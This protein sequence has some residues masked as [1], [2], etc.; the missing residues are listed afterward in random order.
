MA[1]AQTQH[2]GP[3]R[4]WF[5][6]LS[7]TERALLFLTVIGFGFTLADPAIYD[8]A[9]QLDPHTRSL[10]DSI[11]HFGKSSWIL[12]PTGLVFIV[13]MALRTPDM[14]RR[15]RVALDHWMGVFGITFLAVAGSG[16][17]CQVFKTIIGRARPEFYDTLGPLTFRPLAF[18]SGFASFPSGHATTIFAFAAAVSLMVPPLRAWAFTFAVWVAASRFFIDAHYFTDV[19]AGGI[20]GVGFMLWLARSFAK[21][22]I[23]FDMRDG[24]LELRG[25][26][27]NRWLWQSALGEVRTRLPDRDP[28]QP[29][30]EPIG[31]ADSPQPK[32]TS[33]ARRLA[34][35]RR[36]WRLWSRP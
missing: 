25:R 17:L 30:E 23:V 8:L 1:D 36:G 33:F 14:S 26:L 24:K 20:L 29:A 19:I 34:D 16:L 32:G 18:D 21:R 9:R 28:V 35:Y 3:V 7:A 15:S 11:T 31:A 27:L 4:R 6:E 12:W 22:R 13:L 2:Y 10:F 5:N